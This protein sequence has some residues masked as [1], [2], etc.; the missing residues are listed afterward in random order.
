MVALD[1]EDNSQVV[2]G[3]KVA[4]DPSASTSGKV[5]SRPLP[6]SSPGSGIL[7]LSTSGPRATFSTSQAT[8]PLK[9][10][11]PSPLPSQPAHIALIYTL[12]Y[13]GGLVAGDVISL[14]VDVDQ[15]G[16]LILLTQG[17]TKVFRSRSGIRPLSH[18]LVRTPHNLSKASNGGVPERM[19]IQRMKVNLAPGSFAMIMP[20]SVSPFKQSSYTQSQRFVLPSDGSASVLVLDWFNSGRGASFASEGSAEIWSMDKYIS[21]NEVMLGNQIV[22]REKMSLDNT[23]A[24]I[25]KSK[26]DLTMVGKKLAPYHVYATVL[27]HGPHFARFLAHLRMIVDKTTQYQLKSP[28]SLIWSYSDT[29]GEQG[30]AGVLRLAAGSVEEVRIW[31]RTAME[32]GGMK[33]LVGEGVWPRV[34]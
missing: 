32:Q 7:H 13:G 23:I 20:D 8:Y 11:A 29:S 15:G 6:K 24:G 27:I 34:I 3:A 4:S 18:S 19:T 12:A 14:K 21:T 5:K 28:P 31:L 33:D 16:G 17:S 30:H 10:L 26:G 25:A 9:L 1:H 22:M 2:T